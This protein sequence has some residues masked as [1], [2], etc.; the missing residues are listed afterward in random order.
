MHVRVSRPDGFMPD[1]AMLAARRRSP[2]ATG[3]SAPLEPRPG[4]GGRPAPTSSP[5]TPGSRWARRTRPTRASRRSGRTPSTTELLA[6]AKADAIV[7][8]CLPA[9]RGKE[10][11]AEVIDGPQSVV[12]DEAENRLHAQKALLAWLLGTARGASR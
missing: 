7:L 3:G 10:I 4:R 9:Y 1:P 5:P 6:H 2:P 12:W 11:A 8:H